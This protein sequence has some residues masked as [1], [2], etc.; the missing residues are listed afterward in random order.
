[1]YIISSFDHVDR[2]RFKRIFNKV[3]KG[4]NKDKLKYLLFY[5]TGVN[6]QDFNSYFRFTDEYFLEETGITINHVYGR[7]E[8]V[9]QHLLNEIK[10]QKSDQFISAG[11]TPGDINMLFKIHDIGG[12]SYYV[13]SYYN[14][15]VQ[16]KSVEILINSIACHNLDHSTYCSDEW[17][18]S[19]FLI[20]HK[21]LNDYHKGLI[22]RDK[23]EYIY[24]LLEIQNMH[25]L[26]YENCE[27]T[28]PV[29]LSNYEKKLT[30]VKSID[31]VFNKFNS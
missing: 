4:I 25:N 31:E 30:L 12:K 7:K 13:N 16:D 2:E 22:N 23:L 28:Y 1:M 19:Y 3:S 26:S 21:W 11:D 10:V 5:I 15:V 17:N 9:V 24:S 20:Y 6:R 8:D 27:Q 18:N 14:N 29:D